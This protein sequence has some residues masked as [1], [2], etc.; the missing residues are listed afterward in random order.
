MLMNRLRVNSI[1]LRKDN[2]NILKDISLELKSGQS[3][4]LYGK[5]GAGK[6]S[7]LKCIVGLDTGYQGDISLDPSGN[8][9]EIISYLSCTN[10]LPVTLNV[11]DYIRS[12]KLLLESKNQFDQML[13]EKAYSTFHIKSYQQKNFGSLSKG[14]LKMVFIS[15]TMMKKSDIIVLDE[16]FEGLDIS[17][18]LALLEILISEVKKGKLLIASSH[19]VAE[20]YKSFDQLIG[21]KK[22]RIASVLQNDNIAD[23]QEVINQI[24]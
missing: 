18:K 9:I 23:Y 8:I 13:F 22:G 16:P 12:F 11:G 15:I 7:L 17:M 21:I 5:N 24:R 6:T 19:E 3:Y 20:I 2:D 4:L 1:S 14:M 10:K